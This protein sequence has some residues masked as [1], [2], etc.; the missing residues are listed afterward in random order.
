[1]S[2]AGRLVLGTFTVVVLTLLVL[3]LGA[4]R[5]LRS[6]LEHDVRT[7]LEREARLVAELLP[8]DPGRWQAVVT[9]M[10]A[11]NGHRIVVRD[12]SGVSRA[13]SDS[14]LGP[15]VLRVEVR[16]GPGAIMVAA[17][18]DGVDQA[19]ARARRSMI[20]AA[21]L[22]LVVALVL[23]TIAGRS[24]ASPL[25]GLS[26]AARAI[27]A[28]AAPRFP[29]SGIPEVDALVQAIRQMHRELADRFDDVQ[30]EK[31]ASTAIVDAMGEGII[32]TDTRGRVVVANPAA[33]RLLGYEA[34]DPLP[35]V[36]TLFRVKAAREAVGE[37]LEGQQVQD[38][39]VDL[40]GRTIVI[41]ARPVEGQGVVLIL[42]DLTEVRRLEAIRRDFVA[43]VSH[44]L[45]TPLTSISGYAE[46]LAGGGV[47]PASEAR[48]LKTI[49]TNSHRM[50]VLVDD[51]LD[52]SRIESGRW[53]PR[54]QT[55]VV[56]VAVTEAWSM[57]ADRAAG[58]GVTFEAD[59]DTD[60]ATIQADPDA[61]RRSSATC[62][63]TRCATSS[64]VARSASRRTAALAAS[65]WR[66]TTTARGSR[67]STCHGSSSGSTGSTPHALARRAAPAWG[68]RSSGT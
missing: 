39:E 58:R 10:S 45:K 12:S 41:N 9:R 35:E 55:V 7:G 67:P 15:E 40:D 32:A 52:L 66:S 29:R 5:T 26:G 11:Q 49:L 60:A 37:V 14:L 21:L 65:N 22:A 18:T 51:L 54:L 46:T 4:E 27:A 16:G 44:E 19:V 53:T 63:T 8:D 38:R 61:V 20:G 56:D 17:P 47:D 42:R 13:A 2:F 23:A 31:A 28:G 36:R 50:Q 48:F 34:D 68:S 57:F 6:S 43:N 33:R 59:L 24:V 25:V 1:M 30:R 62:S 3:I 64:A